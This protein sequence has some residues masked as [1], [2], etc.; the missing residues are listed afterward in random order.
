M[1]Q[2]TF[3]SLIGRFATGVTV[4]TTA[5]GER[6]HG[7][8]ANAVA[9]VSLDPLLLLVC[10]DHTA[11]CYQQLLETDRFGV[12]ILGEGQEAVSSTFAT[13]YEPEEG[14][15]RGVPF[16]L[17]ERGVPLLDD[18]LARLECEIE[19]RVP[20]GDHDIVLGRVVAGELVRDGR[21][22]L[23]FAG[24]YARLG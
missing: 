7:M 18:C 2:R 15:L 17:S 8:T 9:S 4:I 1:D 22:L 12:N 16:H 14:T 20:A 19:R 23:F 21:P 13:T 6:L 11:N 24:K 5:V 10:I 3:R